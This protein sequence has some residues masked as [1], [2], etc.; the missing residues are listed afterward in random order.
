MITIQKPVVSA[1][2]IKAPSRKYQGFV[3]ETLLFARVEVRQPAHGGGYFQW[4]ILC[5]I[6]RGYVS[7]RVCGESGKNLDSIHKI[8]ILFLK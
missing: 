3:I 2:F 6:T 7:A 4:R 1:C 5:L 8:K